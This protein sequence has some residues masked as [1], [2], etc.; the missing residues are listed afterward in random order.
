MT[1]PCVCGTVEYR[2]V[3]RPYYS[4]NPDGITRQSDGLMYLA[5][6]ENCGVLRQRK[7]WK[8]AEEQ[9]EFYKKYPPTTKRYKVKGYDHDRNLA[10]KR[11]HDYG[12]LQGERTLDIG[13]GNGAFVDECRRRKVEAYGCEISEYEQAKNFEYIYMKRFET[14]HFPADYFDLI[15]CHD[16]LEHVFD[17]G[18]VLK[19][20]FRCLKQN[21]R[22]ILDF[23]NYYVEEGKHHWKVEHIW[24]FTIKQLWGVLQDIGFRVVG[25]TRPVPGKA[26]LFCTKPEQN[27]PKILLPPGIGDSFWSITK[28]QSFLKKHQLG[29]PDVYIVSPKEKEYNGHMRSV[30]FLQMFPFLNSTGTVY[31]G[32]G[33]PNLQ[34]IWKEAY[35]QEGRTIFQGVLGCDFF[36][37]YNG[38][39]RV[40]KQMENLDP[41]LET[42]WFPPMFV[43]LEQERFK[44]QCQEK[45]GKYIALYFVFQG[46]YQHWTSEFSLDSV[47]DYI[48]DIKS[49]TGLTP[50]L[51]GSEWDRDNQNNRKIVEWSTKFPGSKIVNLLG[52]TSVEQVFGVLRGAEIVVGYPSGLT[53]MSAI[54][55]TKTLIIWNKYY[56]ADFFW[57]CAP[58]ETRGTNYFITDTKG[59]TSNNL[60]KQTKRILSGKEKVKIEPPPLKKKETKLIK[61]AHPVKQ[62][63]NLVTV[64]CVLKSG[65]VYNAEYVDVMANMLKRFISVPYRFRVLTDMQVNHKHRWLTKNWPGWW[66]KVEVFIYPGPA[67]YLDLD[68]VITRNIDRLIVAVSNM[69]DNSVRMLTPFNDVRRRA[70]LW[71]SGVMAWRGDFKVLLK[72]LSSRLI[73]D[74]RMDQTYIAQTLKENNIDIK[75]I[76]KWSEIYSYKRNCQNGL[77]EDSEIVCFHGRHKPK[78][79]LVPWVR[80]LWK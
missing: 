67:L 11:F 25:T 3:E 60:M 29:L 18:L 71:A 26:I 78:D 37:S 12:I 76:N 80:Q 16:S 14:I 47:F 51:V 27:R 63:G 39:L 64:V 73:Q 15:T 32:K 33:R 56:N 21:G 79:C 49:K 55:K 54:F 72:S 19:E 31:S 1:S 69:P 61:T 42:E 62:K 58:P 46:T 48:K 40:G 10:I 38:H 52:E 57:Y 70:G 68:T 50:V 7:P 53:I 35:A 44:K 65:G 41:D 30:P 77:P 13:S 36:I 20:I 66:S 34:K 5:E 6:C 45:Y 4:V 28:L 59:L 74:L 75:P 43:S 23:P 8:T 22:F 9:E 2:P 17:V 24:Y